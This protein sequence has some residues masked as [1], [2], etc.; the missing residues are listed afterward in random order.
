MPVP[1]RSRNETIVIGDPLKPIAIGQTAERITKERA[2]DIESVTAA[3]HGRQ[4]VRSSRTGTTP[5][6]VVAVHED[7]ALL[8]PATQPFWVGP[9]GRWVPALLV[10]KHEESANGKH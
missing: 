5:M 4:T 1:M 2:N 9:V 7:R 3:M 8:I 6:T 10:R